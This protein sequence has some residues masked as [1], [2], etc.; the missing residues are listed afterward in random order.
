MSGNGNS[1]WVMYLV[2]VIVSILMIAIPTLATNMVQNDK[3]A[4]SRDDKISDEVDATCKEQMKINENML[5][6]L[7][8][9]KTDLKYIK[10]KVQ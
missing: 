10:A 5:V 8:E 4:R 2:G 6:A 1:K 9:I 3:D 7:M